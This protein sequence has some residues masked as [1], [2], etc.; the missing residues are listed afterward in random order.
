MHVCLVLDPMGESLSSFPTIWDPAIVPLL[1]AKRFTRQLLWALD[2]AHTAGVIHSGKYPKYS[3]AL[4]VIS[5]IC[6]PLRTQT[7]S[8]TM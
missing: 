1:I 8:Q 5:E 6:F 7:S 4:V 2:Y 3:A